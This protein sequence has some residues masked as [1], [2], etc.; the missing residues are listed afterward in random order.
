MSSEF[1]SGACFS[2][3]GQHFLRKFCG[4]LIWLFTHGCDGRQAKVKRLEQESKMSHAAKHPNVE[5][6]SSSFVRGNWA[7]LLARHLLQ[8]LTGKRQDIGTSQPQYE[9]DVRLMTYLMS[10]R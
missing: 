3:F 8:A 9:V 1:S 4:G 6:A 5:F 7:S 2:R 10:L